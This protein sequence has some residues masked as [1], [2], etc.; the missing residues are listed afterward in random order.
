MLGLPGVRS[1]P[2]P[3]FSR[4]TARRLTVVTYQPEDFLAELASLLAEAAEMNR[5]AAGALTAAQRPFYSQST[6]TAP[7]H[8]RS[9]PVRRQRSGLVSRKM[10][11]LLPSERNG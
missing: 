11:S 3:V 7:N 4:E 9:I 2:T 5:R 6:G 8:S 10:R 1:D